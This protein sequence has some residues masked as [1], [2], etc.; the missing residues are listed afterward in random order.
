M[1][2]PR[3]RA[4]FHATERRVANTYG[5]YDVRT[6]SYGLVKCPNCAYKAPAGAFLMEPKIS[7]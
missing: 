2:C 6:D 1:R 5:V 7:G 3:C 4:A